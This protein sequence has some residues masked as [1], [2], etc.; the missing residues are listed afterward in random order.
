MAD[1]AVKVIVRCRPM[2]EREERLNCEAVVT[3]DT[4]IAQ[5]QL[6]K[7]KSS[8]RSAPPKLFTFDGSY[9]M[10]DTTKQIYDEICFPLVEGVLQGELVGGTLGGGMHLKIVF[11]TAM[12]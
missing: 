5:A 11:V 9:Y 2:N 4:Q 10:L 7:P 12:V 1:E 6:R 8:P 3:M